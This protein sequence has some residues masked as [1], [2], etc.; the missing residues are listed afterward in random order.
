MYHDHYLDFIPLIITVRLSWMLSSEKEMQKTVVSLVTN[1][2]KFN[3]SIWF[4]V[5]LE[6]QVIVFLQNNFSTKKI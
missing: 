2:F 1:I 5:D 6:L 4:S 3:L